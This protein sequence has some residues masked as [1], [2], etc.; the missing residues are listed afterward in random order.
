MI[1]IFIIIHPTNEI[2]E[3]CM[4][5]C[6]VVGYSDKSYMNPIDYCK[7]IYSSYHYRN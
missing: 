2:Y 3:H 6:T 1:V 5:F 4:L 7:K